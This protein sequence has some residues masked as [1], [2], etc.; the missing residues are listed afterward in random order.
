MQGRDAAGRRYEVPIRIF[1][2]DPAFEGVSDKRDITLRIAQWLP[3]GNANLLLYQVE[4]GDHFGDRVFHLDAGV[5]LHEIEIELLVDEEFDGAD[6]GV[7]DASHTLQGGLAQSTPQNGVNHRGRAFL[8]EL[9]M[10]ALDGAFSFTE[11]DQIAMLVAEHLDSM[12]RAR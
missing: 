1:R 8:D 10:P 4:P 6:A 12:W 5:H 11:V 3:G 9:L 7:T 2:V